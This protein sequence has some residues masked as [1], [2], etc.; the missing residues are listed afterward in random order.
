MKFKIIFFTVLFA[1]GLVFIFQAPEQLVSPG[2]LIK[3]H[4][5]LKGNC[6]GCHEP[7]RGP[8]DAKCISC[9]KIEEIGV[10]NSAVRFHQKLTE[11]ACSACHTDHL[12][13]DAKRSTRE[14]DHRF[15]NKD[16][17]GVC[18]DCHTVPK[19]ILHQSIKTN[20]K[21]CHQANKWKPATFDHTRYFRF[22]TDHPEPCDNCHIS[23]Q[24]KTYTCY[25]C[26]EHSKAEVREEHFEEGIR[27]FKNC[28]ECHRSADED[29]AE[30]IWKSKRRSGDRGRSD[31]RKHD[32][33]D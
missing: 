8:S 28:T 25:S 23:G 10:K 24:F 14:F 12:G 6:F 29:E 19:D 18:H 13:R 30:R 27:N 31:R 1:I 20:C 4:E 16:W 3:G 11:K 2:E 22:D 32:D 15:L 21:S 5:K 7:F 9:H 26:H 17:Q 33:D